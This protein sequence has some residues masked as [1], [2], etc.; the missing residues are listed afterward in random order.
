M[1]VD[2]QSTAEI[3]HLIIPE[4]QV[5]QFN[6][7]GDTGIVIDMEMQFEDLKDQNLMEDFITRFEEAR[8]KRHPDSEQD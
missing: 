2:K 1:A 6:S 3:I 8:R 4:R 7:T 5:G